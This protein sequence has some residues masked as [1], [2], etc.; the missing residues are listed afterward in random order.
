MPAPSDPPPP[1]AALRHFD[2]VL[3]TRVSVFLAGLRVT[4]LLTVADTE[5]L[6]LEAV[7]VQAFRVAPVIEAWRSFAL[8]PWHAVLYITEAVVPPQ[9]GS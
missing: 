4:G 6:H 9:T 1:H 5:C 3:G 7:H 2:A 8:V